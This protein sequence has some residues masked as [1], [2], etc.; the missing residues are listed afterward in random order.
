MGTTPDWFELVNRPLLAG[1]VLTSADMQTWSPVCVLTEHGARRLLATRHAI[2]QSVN[3][4]G[5]CT[6]LSASYAMKKQV[7]A[8]KH[9]TRRPTPTFR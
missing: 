1:R 6:G 2:G 3:I 4:G 7:A 8:C 9:P 5:S